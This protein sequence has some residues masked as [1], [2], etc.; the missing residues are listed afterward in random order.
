[1][2]L[3]GVT[4]AVRRARGTAPRARRRK[5]NCSTEL[6]HFTIVQALLPAAPTRKRL[7]RARRNQRTSAFDSSRRPAAMDSTTVISAPGSERLLNA[8]G[9]EDAGGSQMSDDQEWS[10]H[11]RFRGRARLLKKR[12]Q[13]VSLVRG[14]AAGDLRGGAR[15]VSGLPWR[16]QWVAVVS[17]WVPLFRKSRARKRCDLLKLRILAQDLSMQS[18]RAS[19]GRSGNLHIH[20]RAI[21]RLVTF[22]D[23]ERQILRSD[24]TRQCRQARR[25]P[26]Q[27][28]REGRRRCAP[29]TRSR[30]LAD[31][32]GGFAQGRF[33][34]ARQDTLTVGRIPRHAARQP[35]PAPWMAPSSASQAG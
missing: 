8:R 30:V 24:H 6:L 19:R 29:R 27:G 18:A 34:V 22:R 26:R 3:P 31:T 7:R 10:R 5:R 33:V 32:L 2:S 9:P 12:A 25:A 14:K 1:M 11:I 16:W 20:A 35:S 13:S 15:D 23:T 4:L 21:T 28:R 17:G